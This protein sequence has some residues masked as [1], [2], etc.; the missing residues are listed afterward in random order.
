MEEN[1]A[2]SSLT[3]L[4]PRLALRTESFPHECY[5]S[6]FE[7]N[8]ICLATGKRAQGQLKCQIALFGMEMCVS[9]LSVCFVPRGHTL[10]QSSSAICHV[11]KVPAC[12][13]VTGNA[14]S[15]GA[16]RKA[17]TAAGLRDGPVVHAVV[18][19]GPER[20]LLVAVVPGLD[21]GHTLQVRCRFPLLPKV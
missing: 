7:H 21:A 11:T 18:G 12:L 8:S 19:G 4:S 13:S 10:G 3:L 6:S 5:V 16:W 9:I 1:L 20:V 14:L 2:F 17:L 15:G